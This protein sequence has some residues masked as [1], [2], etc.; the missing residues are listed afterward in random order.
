MEKY[1][2]CNMGRARE[3]SSGGREG[4]RE[5]GKKAGR[6]DGIFIAQ[7]KRRGDARKGDVS[8]GIQECCVRMKTESEPRIRV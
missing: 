3:L 7:K 5:E 1:K 2:Y 4:G 6:Q 8:C